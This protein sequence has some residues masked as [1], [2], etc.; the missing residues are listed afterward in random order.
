MC[1]C[2]DGCRIFW[3]EFI[4][5]YKKSPCLWKISSFEYSNKTKKAAAY[6]ILVNKLKEKDETATKDTVTKKIN[7]LRSSFRKEHK[8]VMR[9]MESGA[10]GDDVYQPTLWYYDMLLFLKD[11]EMPTQQSNLRVLKSF[12][13]QEN[14]VLMIVI[15]Y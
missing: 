9:S 2:L 10:S 15:L 12:V 5:L 8:K 11:Q 1:A 14:L 7:N 3:S 6:D 13:K 4:N